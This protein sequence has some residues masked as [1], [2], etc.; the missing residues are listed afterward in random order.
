MKIENEREEDARWIA[1]LPDFPGA[2]AYGAARENAIANVQ[3][4]AFSIVA[5]EYEL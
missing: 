4:L 2:M 3:T 1:E 5:N